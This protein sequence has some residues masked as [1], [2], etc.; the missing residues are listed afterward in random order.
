MPSQTFERL[1]RGRNPHRLTLRARLGF[2]GQLSRQ[3]I[4]G[5]LTLRKRFLSTML[6]MFRMWRDRDFAGQIALDNTKSSA[7]T[8]F[9]RQSDPGTLVFRAK[10]PAVT[11][12]TVAKLRGDEISV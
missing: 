1:M 6:N 9:I 4:A 2:L 3:F 5:V 8:A 7:L 12:T 11:E 10:A